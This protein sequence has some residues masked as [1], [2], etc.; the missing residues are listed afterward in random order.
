MNREELDEYLWRVVDEVKERLDQISA[1][2]ERAEND[3]GAYEQAMEAL[4]DLHRF[5]GHCLKVVDNE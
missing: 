1:L 3:P 4:A 5:T 2:A